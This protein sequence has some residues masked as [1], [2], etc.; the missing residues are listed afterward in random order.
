MNPRTPLIAVLLAFIL[1]IVAA[2]QE[3]ERSSEP[4]VFVAAMAG[5]GVITG[6]DQNLGGQPARD[7]SFTLG[8]KLGYRVDPEWSAGVY[9]Q[10][11]HLVHEE[12]PGGLE[13][14]FRLWN[15]M[16]EA[17][18]HMGALYVGV[19][20]GLAIL[21]GDGFDTTSDFAFGPA[22][23]YDHSLGNGNTSVFGEANVILNQTSDAF[24]TINFFAGVKQRF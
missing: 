13:I 19:K 10:W 7:A 17:N 11:M 2:A 14:D 24:S 8:A 18:Y 20:A 6:L 12:L 1:P 5:V 16:A 21:A 22:V 9:G 3:A 23:G 15:L 4:G